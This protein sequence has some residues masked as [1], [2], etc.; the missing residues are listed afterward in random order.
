M[1]APPAGAG[2]PAPVVVHEVDTLS[3]GWYRMERYTVELASGRQVREVCHRGD[4]AAVLLVHRRRR[5]IVLIRQFR[6]PVLVNGVPDGRLLEVPGG[7]VDGEDPEAAA[8]REVEEE[9]GIRPRGLRRLLLAHM[10]PSL[11]TERVHL[12][13]AEFDDSD[14]VGDGG[15]PADEAAGIETVECAVAEVFAM[16]ERGEIVDGRTLLLL[17]C[18]RTH[19]LLPL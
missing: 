16:V 4:S 9:T 1:T 19:G 14:R 2:S 12:F 15:G 6:L 5:T 3:S 13:I 10:T 17:Y 11:V 8:R 18:A 7:L